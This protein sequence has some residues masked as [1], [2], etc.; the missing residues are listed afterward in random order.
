MGKAHGEAQLENKASPLAPP[1]FLQASQSDKDNLFASCT[2]TWSIPNAA[3]EIRLPSTRFG[4]TV[5]MCRFLDASICIVLSTA[6]G[7]SDTTWPIA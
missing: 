5:I 4:K 7:V 3:I 6:D 1:Q 2:Q